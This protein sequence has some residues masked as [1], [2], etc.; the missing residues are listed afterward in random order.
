MNLCQTSEFVY[1]TQT[2][3]V[4]NVD[5]RTANRWKPLHVVRMQVCPQQQP[6]PCNQT[7]C[8]CCHVWL[9]SGTTR[10]GE[11]EPVILIGRHDF[12]VRSVDAETGQQRWNVTYAA[13]QRLSTPT[14]DTQLPDLPALQHQMIAA[15]MRPFWQSMSPVLVMDS[16]Q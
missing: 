12:V 5:T 11:E 1:L 10:Q 16:V 6:V 14:G 7:D 8:Q 4:W 13:I 9:C 2:A 15:G 3:A